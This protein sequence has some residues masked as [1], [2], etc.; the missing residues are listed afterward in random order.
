MFLLLCEALYLSPILD[1]LHML[2]ISH[3]FNYI[4]NT[5]PHPASPIPRHQQ[6]GV[7]GADCNATEDDFSPLGDVL[8][9]QRTTTTHEQ[10]E[11]VHLE[12]V[13]VARGVRTCQPNHT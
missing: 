8:D 3:S 5:S 12:H 9:A 6:H 4:P 1:T 11:H 2:H 7:V 10:V 13:G